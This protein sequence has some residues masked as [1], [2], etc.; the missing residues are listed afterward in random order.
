[1]KVSWSLGSAVADAPVGA[2]FGFSCGVVAFRI[3]TGFYSFCGAGVFCARSGGVISENTAQS[4]KGMYTF[5]R[6]KVFPLGFSIA[7]G[8]FP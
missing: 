8:E 4:R 7:V 6:D 1:M 2:A 3:G 5:P